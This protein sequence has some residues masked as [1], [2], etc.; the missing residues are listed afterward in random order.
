MPTKFGRDDNGNEAICLIP[1]N[2]LCPTISTVY[3]YASCMS[4]HLSKKQNKDKEWVNKM[5]KH[6]KTLLRH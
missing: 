3:L 5:Y 2:V 6:G 1:G 4:A